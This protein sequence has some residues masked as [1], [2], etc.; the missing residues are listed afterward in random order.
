MQL[1][2]INLQIVTMKYK[3]NYNLNILIKSIITNMVNLYNK[4]IKKNKIEV[5]SYYKSLMHYNS[6]P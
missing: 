3:Y 1:I 5:I 2:A 4:I 6:F